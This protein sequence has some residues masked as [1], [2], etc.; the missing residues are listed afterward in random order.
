MCLRN[1]Y[2][3]RFSLSAGSQ[4]FLNQIRLETIISIL[5]ISVFAILGA[6]LRIILA[7]LF[8]GEC[9]YPGT[10]GWLKT[11]AALCI[12]AYG[13]TLR[14]GGI[15]YADIPSNMFGSFLMGLFLS[16]SA[17]GLHVDV[18]FGVAPITSQFQAWDIVHLGI[19]TGFCG[20]LTTYSSW[21]SEMVVM[22]F[23][24]GSNYQSQWI[25]ALFGYVIG[26]ELAMSSFTAGKNMAI[27]YIR[28]SNPSFAKEADAIAANDDIFLNKSLPGFERRFL[29]NIIVEDE[30]N[31]ANQ[32][33]M[34]ELQKWKDSTASI[35][36]T[37]DDLKKVLHDVEKM[38][39]V[40]QVDP[41]QQ[42]GDIILNGHWD[43]K[44]LE[45]WAAG[46]QRDLEQ[47]ESPKIWPVQELRF[48]GPVLA[49]FLSV[50]I[51][52][53]ILC[54]GQDSYSLTYRSMWYSALWAPP[55]AM[56][57]WYL[58]GLNK[59]LDGSLSWLPLGTLIANVLGSIISISMI[60]SELQTDMYSYFEGYGTMG[61]VKVGFAGS[62][63][64]VST[65][66]SE[67]TT[68][69]KDFPRNYNGYIYIA[70]SLFLSCL[71][72]IVVYGWI[73]YV[74]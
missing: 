74:D 27:F 10:V 34:N 9:S 6:L 8:G 25:R 37:R 60:A 12:T 71:C 39:I 13:E 21:N 33:L 47:M 57:R 58:S 46:K 69:M 53:V 49:A 54:Y 26:I 42:Y 44:A 31:N 70:L 7:Q 16:G 50:L 22:I 29:A 17:L 61:A 1:P 4:S 14:E 40:E 55:G 3:L 38:V 52:G 65:F 41:S 72:G 20:S 51:V 30:L 36:E 68:L 5:Y 18:P 24:T 56:L 43:L 32:D 28:W 59:T 11:E 2:Y 45:R 67:V 63:S 48:I 19:R 73:L 66:V 23:G 15:I 64:T 35:R 62:L